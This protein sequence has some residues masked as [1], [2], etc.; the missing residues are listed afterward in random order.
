MEDVTFDEALDALQIQR[1]Y[2]IL[3]LHGDGTP[4][5]STWGNLDSVQGDYHDFAV[6]LL[7]PEKGPRLD[8]RRE[9][10][11]R[12]QYERG[13]GSLMYDLADGI[14]I[15]LAVHVTN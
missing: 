1:E 6:V 11:T 3:I 8:L 10:V 7:G 15:I 12:I 14:R 4:L 5:L 2:A 9:A 13:S